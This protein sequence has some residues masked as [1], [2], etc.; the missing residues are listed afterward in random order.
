R[1]GERALREENLPAVE[2]ILPAVE[3]N[4]PVVEENLPAVEENI[5]DECFQVTLH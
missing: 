2:E 5:Q 1:F 4:L 3:E